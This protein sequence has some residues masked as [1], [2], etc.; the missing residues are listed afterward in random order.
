VTAAILSFPKR[1][2]KP[3]DWRNQEIAEFHR[4]V[5]ALSQAGFQVETDRGL[6]DE[7]EPWFVF[8][9]PD[10]GEVIAHFARLDGAFVADAGLFDT[11]V[12]ANDLREALDRIL[13]QY[14]V[15]VPRAP[16]HTNGTR[17][18]IHPAAMLT[19]VLA[20]AL[21]Q[22]RSEDARAGGP[23]GEVRGGTGLN[24]AGGSDHG[25]GSPVQTGALMTAAIAAVGLA[26]TPVDGTTGGGA[27][28]APALPGIEAL[29][30]VLDGAGVPESEAAAAHQAP[31]VG[32][33]EVALAGGGAD[34]HARHEVVPDPVV[35][36]AEPAD[37][38][39]AVTHMHAPRPEVD[40]GGAPVAPASGGGDT[41]TRPV[42]RLVV[43]EDGGQSAFTAADS[44]QV[45]PVEFQGVTLDA[46]GVRTLLRA[47][48][49]DD[50]EGGGTPAEGGD[51][52]DSDT[53]R[54][55]GIWRGVG[56]GE[57]PDESDGES[58]QGGDERE[59]GERESGESGTDPG[60]APDD[61][62]TPRDGADSG[63][64]GDNPPE[65]GA[66]EDG[67]ETGPD[68]DP[69]SAA[70]FAEL[71]ADRAATLTR[72]VTYVLDNRDD[73]Q[74]LYL[75]KET[76]AG[77]TA[78]AFQEANDGTLPTI[79]AFESDHLDLDAFAFMPE[80][81]FM[82]A[83][84]LTPQLDVDESPSLD[85]DLAEGGAVSLVGIGSVEALTA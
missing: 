46:A 55:E 79:V 71:G 74:K 69:E 39:P 49:P 44:L 8:A 12:R 64:G 80:V 78:E 38:E 14:A 58:G 60:D 43:N 2:P 67:N 57:E 82:E 24:K 37:P 7:G 70:E 10:S 21:M 33:G 61:G 59:N 16:Q 25:N 81:I 76:F 45:D 32:G 52:S 26:A 9:R 30:A 65:Q 51:G 41:A 73:A 29:A 48:L 42:P 75:D 4:A 18:S 1:A 63:E 11:P 5:D 66:P 22:L 13:D 68:S 3:R 85:I 36:R 28:T 83:D 34:G 23:G 72:S 31:L 50:E 27:P 77:S 19:A 40:V 54:D 47:L 6:T 84:A 20:T 56:P 62:D 15:L 53:N 35:L 17:L